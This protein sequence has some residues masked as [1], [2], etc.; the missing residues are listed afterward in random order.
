MGSNPIIPEKIG[1]T[2]GEI[3]CVG[4]LGCSI[5]RLSTPPCLYNE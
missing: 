3:N 2:P 1:L 5:V 4:D